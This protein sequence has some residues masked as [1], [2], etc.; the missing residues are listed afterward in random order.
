MIYRTDKIHKMIIFFLLINIRFGLLAGIWWSTCISKFQGI[1]CV[2]FSRTNSDLSIYHLVVWSNF[3]LWHNSQWI[4]FLTKSCQ[5]LYFFCASLLHSLIKWL[6]ISCLS[7]H[8]LHLLF[9]VCFS[10]YQVGI[11]TRKHNFLQIYW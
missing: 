8:T 4:T 9:Y 10:Y 6:A 5:V 1:L 7:T 2:S 3:S 11:V